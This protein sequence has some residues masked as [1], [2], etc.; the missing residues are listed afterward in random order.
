MQTGAYAFGGIASRGSG[1]QETSWRI[2]KQVQG[3]STRPSRDL[4]RAL[5]IPDKGP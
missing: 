3:C 2:L 4:C 5:P 1:V